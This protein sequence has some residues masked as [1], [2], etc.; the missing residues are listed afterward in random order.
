[1]NPK[2]FELLEKNLRR[3]KFL[4]IF[5]GS[6]LLIFSLFIITLSWLNLSGK[7]AF[8]NSV[9]FG[10]IAFTGILLLKNAYRSFVDEC[11]FWNFFLRNESNKIVWVYYHKLES[12]PFGISFSSK[13]TLF[14]HLEDRSKACI[15]MR[16]PEILDIIGMFREEMP[17]ATFGYSR[18]KEQLYNIGPD[19]LRK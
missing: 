15:T 12:H 16:E 7:I 17:Q 9:L 19:L 10:M 1:M 2:I 11:H 14:I 6:F 5:V 4:K 3:Q 13:T 8:A 18:Q